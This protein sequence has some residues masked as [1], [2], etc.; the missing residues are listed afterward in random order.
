ME[1]LETDL[2]QLRRQQP[3]KKFTEQQSASFGIQM[4]RSIQAL[5]EQGYIH[6]DIKPSNFLT[7]FDFKNDHCR[8]ID[9]GLARRYRNED[10]SLREVC[11]FS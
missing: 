8:L 2:V 11:S 7:N 5:H 10:G 3:E 6:R 1:L 4:I 9:F